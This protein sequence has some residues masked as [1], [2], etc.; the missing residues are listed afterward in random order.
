MSGLYIHIPFCK[1]ACHYCD[2]HFSTSLKLKPLFL[3]AIKKEIELQNNFLKEPLKS[4]YFGGGTP[5]ILS[6]NELIEIIEIIKHNF[7]IE[8]NI[9]ITLEAN[10]DD[11][12]D[13]KKFETLKHAGINRL[14]IGI[15]SF[16]KKVLEKLNRS[17]DSDLAHK[18]IKTAK[19]IG[20]SNISCD[21]IYGIPFQEFNSFKHSVEQLIEYEIP[22][23]SNYCLTIEENTVFGNW[24]K[25]KKIEYPKEE[26]ILK[27]FNYMQSAFKKA[28]YEQ[29]EISNF[30]KKGLESFHNSNYWKNEPYLGVGPSA[31]SYDGKNRF[32]NIC[33]NSK[34]NKS[35]LDNNEIPSTKEVLT[36]QDR[37]NEYIM[38]RIRTAWGINLAFLKK[39]LN[40]DLINIKKTYIEEAIKNKLLLLNSETLKLSDK[41]KLLADEISLNL[42]V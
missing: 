14:S 10:P 29:Y 7:E 37:I 16:D 19:K 17:H 36:P 35:I 27:E 13:L 31:H 4:I 3:S 39:E 41:G 12:N 6:I 22:H 26:A 9:E 25:K 33:N 30:A 28:S 42:F 34:Y 38:T 20:F 15:Q 24:H 11:F 2:F 40:H 32:H 18:A 1:K 8:N 5:S 23:I 21:L